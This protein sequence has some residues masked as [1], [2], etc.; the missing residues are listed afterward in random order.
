MSHFYAMCYRENGRVNVRKLTYDY[1]KGPYYSVPKENWPLEQHARVESAMKNKSELLALE[2]GRRS[3]KLDIFGPDNKRTPAA[4]LYLSPM[5]KF[6]IN[7][8]EI[9]LE[10]TA[11]QHKPVDVNDVQ[12]KDVSVRELNSLFRKFDS[13]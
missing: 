13:N 3:V 8:V 5:G 6:I 2:T 1:K 4:D 7:G 9:P 12:D 10:D 11:T